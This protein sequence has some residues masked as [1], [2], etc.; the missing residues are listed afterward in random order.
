MMWTEGTGLFNWFW[1][2]LRTGFPSTTASSCA[3]SLF[4]THYYCPSSSVKH[5][6]SSFCCL[7]VS[8]KMQQ[9][10]DCVSK[11]CNCSEQIQSLQSSVN[12]LQKRIYD[13]E[14]K[15]GIVVSIRIFF[16]IS[17]L[18]KIIS[19]WNRGYKWGYDAAV[20]RISESV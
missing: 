12:I 1:P 16:L 4:G 20:P 2:P 18:L 13:L 3:R 11:T 5:S 8:H 10:K 19:A 7:K 17:K 6:L 15:Q 9:N 14:Q